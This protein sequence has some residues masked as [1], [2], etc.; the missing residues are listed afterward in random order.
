MFRVG[1]NTFF[2]GEETYKYY[3]YSGYLEANRVTADLKINLGFNGNRSR[4]EFSFDTSSSGQP[5]PLVT[6][7]GVR[8]SSNANALIVKS[9]NAHWSLG[10]QANGSSNL[11]SN[12]KL[13]T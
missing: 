13:G 3:N 5:A 9:L 6:E 8:R 12:L 4:E 7:V 2:N 11:R 1:G 10:L